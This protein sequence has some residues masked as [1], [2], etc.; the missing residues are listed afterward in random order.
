M[1]ARVVTVA[2][3]V[4]L[5]AAGTG[6]P[7]AVAVEPPAS[8]DFVEETAGAYLDRMAGTS[9]FAGVRI[10]PDG[11]SIE[12]FTAGDGKPFQDAAAATGRSALFS[13]TRV[14][15]AMDTLMAVRDRLA[16]QADALSKRGVE[17][18]SWGPDVLTNTVRVVVTDDS[19]AVRSLL[20]DTFGPA[21]RV[22]R[23]RA[24]V[25]V[26]SRLN[27]TVPWDGGVFTTMDNAEDCTA[28]PP[29]YKPSTGVIY[30]LSA[31][32]CYLQDQATSGLTGYIYRTF[33]GSRAIPSGI[34]PLMGY[35]AAEQVQ[36]G[37]DAALIAAPASSHDWRTGLAN[38][39][40][41]PT[42]QVSAQGSVVGASVCA[43][44]AFSGERCGAIV[45]YVNQDTRSFGG[46]VQ[47]NM[48]AAENPNVA[49]VG[50]GDSGGPVYQVHANGLVMTGMIIAKGD[51]SMDPF[52]VSLLCPQNDQ[53]NR[54]TTCSDVV[55]YHDLPSLMNHLG[56]ALRT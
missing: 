11:T 10:R 1:R 50:P 54:G 8:R 9:G 29:V 44:G 35:A 24:P 37:Y 7:G 38:A 40:T 48:V 46:F 25:K 16:D 3:V 43:S 55:W 53:G 39:T 17:L 36:N 45:R 47:V 21:I 49:I 32:H 19:A 52:P 14:P 22:A 12:V 6:A 30:L 18:V 51:D 15:Y 13:F 34:S 27:D 33:Q 28:G 23:G 41:T 5:F 26:A 42:R 2:V 31:G 56:V 20:R 4:V